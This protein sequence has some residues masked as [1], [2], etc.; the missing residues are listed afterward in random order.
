MLVCLFIKN[1]HI[2]EG[3]VYATHENRHIGDAQCGCLKFAA[4]GKFRD[5]AGNFAAPGRADLPRLH[6]Q[7]IWPPFRGVGHTGGNYSTSQADEEETEKELEVYTTTKK[8]RAPP[9]VRQDAMDEPGRGANVQGQN[10]RKPRG[11]LPVRRNAMVE[12]GEE[13]EGLR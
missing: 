11:L 13:K 8:P 9:P 6:P 3:R 1:H 4:A 5:Y 12:P 2:A 7:R 10:P